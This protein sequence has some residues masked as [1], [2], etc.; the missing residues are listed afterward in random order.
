MKVV[1]RT[2]ASLHIGTGHVMRCLTLAEALR[3]CGA[4]CRFICRSHPGNLIK[5][6][7]QRGFDVA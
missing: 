2:D 6:I 5:E 3:E 7:G 1:F 4:H